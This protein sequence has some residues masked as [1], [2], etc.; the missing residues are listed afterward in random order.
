MNEPGGIEAAPGACAPQTGDADLGDEEG[1]E[2]SLSED[3]P[4]ATLG[5]EEEEAG[6]DKTAVPGGR[7]GLAFF[8]SPGGGGEEGEAEHTRTR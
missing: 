8:S 3:S 7:I 5:D 6:G 2:L 4:D 1:E